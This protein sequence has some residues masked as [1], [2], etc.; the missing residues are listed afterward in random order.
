MPDEERDAQR[1]EIEERGLGGP[2]PV[3][4]G[5][6]GP[7]SPDQRYFFGKYRGLVKDNKD[8][9]GL[10]RIQV[11]VPAVAGVQ[12]AWA[13]PAT[14]YAGEKVGF[15]TIPPNGAL[16]WVEFEGGHPDF[17][18]W[19]GCFWKTDQVPEEVKTNADDPSQVKVFKTRVLTM[20]VD[21]TDKKGQSVVVFKDPSVSESLEITIKMD[22]KILTI[23][24]KGSK[25][26]TEITADDQDIKTTSINLATET[27][28]NTDLKATEKM[29]LDATGD[30]TLKTAAALK[31]TATKDITLSGANIKGSAQQKVEMTGSSGATLSTSATAEIKGSMVKIDGSGQVA[32]SGGL[33]K[34]N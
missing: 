26:T 3:T 32:V 29:T 15:Y 25:G 2:M 28:K 5:H 30:L 7:G 20:W 19:T 16:V 9:D 23:T 12:E 31:A 21:D 11:Q 1:S 17:P 18:I 24:C 34:L 14:P 10:G 8:P 6:L 13:L 27:S 33:V 4:V 22:P